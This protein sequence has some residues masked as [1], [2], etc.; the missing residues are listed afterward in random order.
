[1]FASSWFLE[2]LLAPNLEISFL[3]NQ[4]SSG[5]GFCEYFQKIKT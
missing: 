1:M 5:F 4:R 3:Q 2:E